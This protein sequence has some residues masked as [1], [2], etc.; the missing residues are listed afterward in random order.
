MGGRR[1]LRRQRLGFWSRAAAEARVDRFRLIPY[2]WENGMRED[3]PQGAIGSYIYSGITMSWKPIKL[4]IRIYVQPNTIGICARISYKKLYFNT[5][6]GASWDPL[7]CS[8]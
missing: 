6:D 4:P 7:P 3:A 5:G 8:A 2:K 1:E